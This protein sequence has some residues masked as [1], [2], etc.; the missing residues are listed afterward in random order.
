ME[1]LVT[2]DTLGFKEGD[3]INPSRTLKEGAYSGDNFISRRN[4][5]VLKESLTAEDLAIIDTIIKKKFS[6]LF[7]RLYTRQQFLLK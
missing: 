3:I 1:L 7:W 5:I 6:I 2:K 4:Y